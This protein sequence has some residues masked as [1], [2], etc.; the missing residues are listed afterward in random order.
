MTTNPKRSRHRS[1]L[2]QAMVLLSLLALAPA[3]AAVAEPEP[4][5]PVEKRLNLVIKDETGAPTPARVRV[6]GSDGRVHPDTLDVA[7]MTHLVYGKYFYSNSDG[8]AWVNVP[9]GWTRVTI[10]KGFEYKAYDRSVLISRDTTLVVQLDRPINLG[11]DGWYSGDVHGHANHGDAHYVITPALGKRAVSA[12]GLDIIHFLDQSDNFTGGPHYL[13][14][15]KTIL[16]Y[17]YEYRNQAGGHVALPG[18]RHATGT[19]CCRPPYS[20][21]PMITDLRRQVVPNKGPLIT[22]AHPHT[23]DDYF[24]D[25]GWPGWGLGREGP[26]LAGLGD[27][28]AFDVASYNNLGMLDWE[29]WYDVIASGRACTPSAGTDSPLNYVYSPP[30]GGLRVYAQQADH[31]A[32]NYDQWIEAYVAGRTFVTNYPLIPDFEV[33]GARPPDVLNVDGD[34][35]SLTVRIHALCAL[36]LQRVALVAD[37][38]EVWSASAL[39]FPPP[40]EVDTTFTIDLPAPSFVC[41]RAV[42]FAG[43]PHALLGTPFAQTNAVRFFRDG[44]PIRRTDAAARLLDRVD[45]YEQFAFERGGWDA[46][47]EVDSVSVRLERARRF[48]ESA[49]VLAPY[50][51]ALISPAD[52]DTV[53]QGSVLLTWSEATDPEPGDKV[54]YLVRVSPDSMMYGAWM[55]RVGQATELQNPPIQPDRWYWWNVTATD[56]N[57]N[58]TLSTPLKQSFFLARSIPQGTGDPPATAVAAPRSVPNPAVSGPIRIEGLEPPVSIFDVAGRLVGTLEGRSGEAVVWAGR[59]ASG[60]KAPPGLYWARGRKQGSHPVRLIIAP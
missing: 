41:A 5:L 51:F 38:Q 3:T 11:A 52:R 53:Q 18:L 1:S 6:L 10:G 14:D 31:G 45:L 55:F 4:P 48:F 30:P 35:V 15:A 7:R 46:A 2:V 42:G 9:T 12:E 21:I 54:E 26:V 57:G 29:T 23:T 36:S 60:A 20:V 49:F 13:S 25:E 44:A 19:G 58:S 59:M 8:T 34:V 43:H 33:N 40:M 27:L 16:Y 22:L 32:L 47:W 28:D 24:Y 17:S 50:P 39:G 56:R 37:G